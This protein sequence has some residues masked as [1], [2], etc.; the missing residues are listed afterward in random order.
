MTHTKTGVAQASPHAE[1]H[2]FTNDHLL[3][4]LEERALWQPMVPVALEELWF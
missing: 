4:E 3:E 1:A 2:P